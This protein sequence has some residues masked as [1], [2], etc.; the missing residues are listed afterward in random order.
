MKTRRP[1]PQLAKIHRNDSVD[2]VARLFGKHKN[3]VRAWIK[4]GLP[5]CDSRRPTLILGHSLRQFLQAKRSKNKKTCGPSELYCVRCREPRQPAGG[6]AE[7]QPVT[8]TFGN[9]AGI[10]PVCDCIINRRMSLAK[11]SQIRGNLDITF[12]QAARHIGETSQPSINSDFGKE[13]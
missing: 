6:M 12:V 1:N 9:L 8:D 4:D 11:V 7:Y 5:T 13:G 2:E 3:T 10:C